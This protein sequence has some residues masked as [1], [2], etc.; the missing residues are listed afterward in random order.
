MEYYEI[1]EIMDIKCEINITDGL[2]L[3][4][5]LKLKLIN[6]VY[7]NPFETLGMNVLFRDLS[8]FKKI[9]NNVFPAHTIFKTYN[10]AIY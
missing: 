5:Y 10:A 8:H 9:E 2:Y 1:V 4:K 6:I 3:E 7:L